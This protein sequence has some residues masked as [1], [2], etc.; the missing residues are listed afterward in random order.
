MPQLSAVEE[1]EP[2]RVHLRAAIIDAGDHPQAERAHEELKAAYA[3]KARLAAQFTPTVDARRGSGS[4]T[5]R[6]G[7]PPKPSLT[8]ENP[9]NPG[10]PVL[11]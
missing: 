4:T 7:P 5:R 6:G 2:A 1:I 3:A 8:R 11:T 9:E 10:A